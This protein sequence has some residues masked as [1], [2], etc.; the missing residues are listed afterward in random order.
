VVSPAFIS[1]VRVTPGGFNM[2]TVMMASYRL[3]AVETELTKQSRRM[4]KR[5]YR[6]RASPQR[7]N[8]RRFYFVAAIQFRNGVAGTSR[9][10][11]LDAFDEGQIESYAQT[12]PSAASK[13]RL[14]S[15]F[16]T[17]MNEREPQLP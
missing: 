17:T 4:P 3:I 8:P 1:K 10:S 11:L 9:L 6:L 15:C 12:V 16:V 5:R 14:L 13:K 2:A 7:F